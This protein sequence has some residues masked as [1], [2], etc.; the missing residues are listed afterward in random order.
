LQI[1]LAVAL[2]LGFHVTGF[3]AGA[4]VILAVFAEANVELRATQPAVLGAGAAAFDLLTENADKILG[5][6]RSLAE[7]MV[8]CKVT[9]GKNRR[10]G[11]GDPG[12]HFK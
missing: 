1:S 4:A 3:T 5:H 11:T 2:V 7:G 12:E 6:R 8:G 10:V 9:N